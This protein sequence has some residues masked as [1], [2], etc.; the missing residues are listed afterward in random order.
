MNDITASARRAFVVVLGFVLVCVAI[1]I[2]LFTGTQVTVPFLENER[3]YEV[4]AIVTDVDNLVA[5]GQVRIAGV[6]V[7]EVRSTTPQ[8][9]G[10]HVVIALDED[11]APLHEGVAVRVGARSLVGES[12]LSVTDGAGPE[13]PSG[14]VLPGG[15]VTPSVDV[16]DVVHTFDPGTRDQMGQLVRTAGAGTQGTSDGVDGVLAGLGDLGRSGGSAVDALAAQS[17]SLKALTSETSTLMGA[18]DAGDGAVADLVSN[19]RVITEATSGQAKEIEASVRKLPG[20][21]GSTRTATDKLTELGTALG[22]VAANLRESGGPL[23]EALVEL[24]ATSSDLRGLLPPLDG[25]LDRSPDTLKRLPTFSEDVRGVVGPADDALAEV[26]PMLSYARPYGPELAGFVANFN[27]MLGYRDEAGVH[28]ARLLALGNEGVAQLPV[29]A[30]VLTYSNPHPKPGTGT[31]P[32]PFTGPYP[33]V[34][35]A[36]R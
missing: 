9:D 6:Q 19:S 22:P 1:V 8:P 3:S 33:R 32:G 23:S 16:R 34:E 17:E 7:G 13:I 4:S 21:L 28:Y 30:G 35:R 14:T 2:Y 18:L 27:A 24:P 36:P 25:V 10:M 31:K 29:D 12:Y 20:V 11:V 15:A 5:A 26:G